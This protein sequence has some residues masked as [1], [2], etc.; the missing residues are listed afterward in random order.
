MSAGGEEG[1]GLQCRENDECALGGGRGFEWWRQPAVQ[2]GGVMSAGGEK[3]L[4]GSTW[5]A[6]GRGKRASGAAHGVQRG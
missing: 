1:R 5:G 3:G 2:G 6:E 4:G